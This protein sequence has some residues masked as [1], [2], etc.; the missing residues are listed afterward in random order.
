MRLVQGLYREYAARK[1]LRLDPGLGPRLAFD[2][3]KILEYKSLVE[4]EF[5][6]LGP[7]NSKVALAIDSNQTDQLSAGIS[8][9][10]WDVTFN[11]GKSLRFKPYPEL[12]E[13][14]RVQNISEVF[15]T[16]LTG[17][18]DHEIGHWE[19]PRGSYFGCP[20]DK[21]TYYLSFV[22]V[23]RKVAKSAGM[24]DGAAN[25]FAMRMANTVSDVI[26]NYNV[27]T[28]LRSIGRSFS[29]QAL[30]WYIEG[31]RH[32]TFG[33]EYELFVRLNLE[34]SFSAAEMK[35]LNWFLT[36]RRDILRSVSVLEQIFDPSSM[37]D[38]MQWPRLVEAYC[39]EAI[40]YFNPK[41]PSHHTS[42]S[43]KSNPN[44]E[45]NPGAELTGTDIEKI[46]SGYDPKSERP[47]YIERVSG[48]DAYYRS[49]ARAIPIKTIKTQMVLRGALQVIPLQLIPFDQDIHDPTDAVFSKLHIDPT[50][51]GV[52]PSVVGMRAKLDLPITRARKNLPDFMFTLID[53]SYSMMG[54]EDHF[55][56]WGTDSGYHYAL[57]TFY[58]LLRFFEQERLMHQMGFSGAI[59]SSDTLSAK[60]LADVKKMILNP[61]SGGTSIDMAAVIDC[62]SAREGSVFLMISDGGIAN[63]DSIKNEFINVARRHEFS[64]IQIGS[65]TAVSTELKAAGFDVQHVSSAQDVVSMAIDLVR[66]KYLRHMD[67]KTRRG[68]SRIHSIK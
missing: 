9:E 54:S 13:Y 10:T 31:Q 12:L 53:S 52:V 43:E 38:R 68:S 3:A 24:D 23:A 47:F 62:L 49:L 65:S 34:L 14:L 48:L 5:R 59:F 40:K 37:M 56:P 22:E 28:S 21:P 58:G 26:N 30:F 55:V 4:H 50:T 39:K 2:G 51:G 33:L 60:S 61:A 11:V 19:F 36:K 18:A 20:Y 44:P 16:Y 45:K 6:D 42:A 41:E 35:L 67:D 63:W 25:A 66:G 17:V 64:M 46:V 7:T 8:P 57:L 15:P 27:S 29:G 1:A 32:G